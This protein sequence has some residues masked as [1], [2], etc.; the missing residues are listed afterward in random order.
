MARA[1][2]TPADIGWVNAHGTGTQP[3]DA[4]EAAA[5]ATVFGN[6]AAPPVS[7]LKGA[8]GHSHGCG[9]GDRGGAHRDRPGDRHDP[10]H[11]SVS[12]SA[13]I[14]LPIDVVDA[15]RPAPAM[16][17]ALNCAYAFGGLNSALLI[18]AA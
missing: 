2:V 12:S 17:W 9:L 8:L 11:P 5:V 6:A 14:A 13:T 4:A 16:R 3:S 18:G 15:P 7:S 10:A 1:S